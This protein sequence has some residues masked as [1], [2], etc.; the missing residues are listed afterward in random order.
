VPPNSPSDETRHAREA[1]LQGLATSA[2]DNLPGVDF[3]SIT[4][5]EVDQTLRTVAATLPLAEQTDALQYD[6]REGPCYAAVTRERLVLVNDMAASTEFPR[7]GPAA[8][9]LGVGS[10]AAIQLIHNGDR[11]GLNLYARQP[12]AF[13][14]S[15]MQLA[16]LF[17]TQAAALLNYAAQV[18][19]LS[20]A[21]HTR[22]DIATAVGI[23]MERYSIDRNQA[24]A[25]LLR[26]SNDRNI[27]IRKLAQ[28]VIEGTFESTDDED[29]RFQ[30]WP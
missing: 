23:V 2:V 10:Q 24:F 5:H 21:L 9:G 4:L 11:A 29:T 7:Y 25:F 27:K 19:Q 15:T 3:A 13:D 1:A 18:E 8:A 12:H 26:N 20:E 22:T 30:Q 17:A 28:H 16:E 14:P 6:L